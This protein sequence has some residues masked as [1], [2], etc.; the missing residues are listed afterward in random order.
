MQTLSVRRNEAKYTGLYVQPPFAL[1]GEGA[2][3]L[4][5]L[6]H[7]FRSFG[8]T[9]ADIRAEHG[10]GAVAEEAIAVHVGSQASFRFTFDRI[11]A[12]IGNFTNG[13][14]DAFG[15][16][17]SNGT[18]WLRSAAPTLSFSSHLFSYACHCAIEG[19]TSSAVLSRFE[20]P[21]IGALGESR[22]N[23]ITWHGELERWRFQLALDHSIVVPDGLFLQFILIT[24]DDATSYPQILAMMR[25]KLSDGLREIGLEFLNEGDR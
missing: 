10:T 7:A 21:R 19:T 2:T 5:G 3:I 14:L 12:S 9:L 20:T 24:L 17:L 13:D 23:G 25:D 1:W 15:E 18:G 4:E 22:G 16:L 11:E 8:V 6:Y